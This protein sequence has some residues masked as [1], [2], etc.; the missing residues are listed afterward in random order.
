[1]ENFSL[2]VLRRLQQWPD[3]RQFATAC[4]W[5]G[6]DAAICIVG[7]QVVMVSGGLVP[8]QNAVHINSFA[9]RQT[10]ESGWDLTFDF[11]GPSH[12][13]FASQQSGRDFV[14]AV[15]RVIEYKKQQIEDRND[16]NNLNSQDRL[17]ERC[18]FLGGAAPP[19][20]VRTAYDFLIQTDRIEIWL[21]PAPATGEP[22]MTHV[23]GPHLSVEISGPG[24]VS[25]G[26]G[27]FGGGF[28]A[29]GAV[30]GM[31][32]A[33]VLNSMTTRTSITTLIT[34]ADDASEAFFLHQSATP[35]EV[36]R[37][38]SPLF[39]SLRRA[40]L[41]ERTADASKD[42]ADLTSRL[43]VLAQ[44]HGAGSL[45]DAEFETAKKSVLDGL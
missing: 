45:S 26:G 24:A 33:S 29:K 27:F 34:V 19:L 42:T 43:A 25:R 6:K 44:L 23:I 9:A 35:E 38:L 20:I 18:I 10:S 15:T 11:G 40:R 39:V 14:E 5:K 32:I 16:P 41:G 31:A 2:R 12:V 17:L 1:M 30:E 22:A 3:G 21:N 37:H 4:T 7:T 28:G 13:T 8:F 36:R